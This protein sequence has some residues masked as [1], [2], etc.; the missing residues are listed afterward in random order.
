MPKKHIAEYVV[1]VKDKASGALKDVGKAAEG[2]DKDVKG[3]SE[4]EKKLRIAATATAK[5]LAKHAAATNNAGQAADNAKQKTGALTVAVGNLAAATA[6]AAFQVAKKLP[7]GFIALGKEAIKVSAKLE[8]F[9]TQLGILLKSAEKGKATVRDLFEISKTT[10]FDVESLVEAET[11]LERFGANAPMW[12]QGVMDLAGMMGTDLVYAAKAVG[13]AVAAGAGAADV[14]R[15]RGISATVAIDSG[16]DYAKMSV[17]EFRLALHKTLTTND[18]IVGGTKKLANSYRGIMSQLRDQWIG[19]AREIGKAKLFEGAKLILK[20]VLRLLKASAGASTSWAK[21]IGESLVEGL[22]LA[23]EIFPMI[24]S[25]AARLVIRFHK[26]R[27]VVNLWK[28][29]IEALKLTLIKTLQVA[30]ELAA[31][32]PGASKVGIADAAKRAK[33]MTLDSADRLR[34]HAAENRT[35]QE[36]IK[37]LEGVQEQWSNTSARVTEI[38]EK[39]ANLPKET[40]LKLELEAGLTRRAL[41]Q[42]EEEEKGKKPSAWLDDSFKELAKQQRKAVDLRSDFL[43]K[44]EKDVGKAQGATE[45]LGRGLRDTKKESDKF[46][47]AQQKLMKQMGK[48]AM[49]AKDLGVAVGG[50]EM[51]SYFASLETEI[52]QIEALRLEA[53]EKEL[54]EAKAVDDALK[55]GKAADAAAA[56]SDVLSA[57]TSGP[58]QM[59]AMAGPWGA[60]AAG[61]I[62]IGRGAAQERDA[63][64]EEMAAE[65]AASRQARLEEERAAMMDAGMGTEQLAAMGLSEEDIAKAGEVTAQDIKSA[66]AMAPEDQEFIGKMV[67]DAVKGLIDGAQ[68]IILALPDIIVELIPPLISE[69]IPKLIGAIFKMIPKLLEAIFYE[70]PIAI[71]DGVADWWRKA[72]RDIKYALNPA[73]WVTGKQT[74]GFIPA[75]GNYLLHQ[76]E[77]VVPSSNAATGTARAGLAAFAPPSATVH[78]N[79]AVVDQDTIPALGR[80]INE[81]LGEFGRMSFPVFNNA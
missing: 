64:V 35:I 42:E 76:G 67:S 62:G 44:L 53:L 40:E 3:L 28:G 8:T 69:F 73:N 70:M 7:L 23:L 25:M 39:L 46:D 45:K 71:A 56:A 12:R 20:E 34:A 77:R 47:R 49:I 79:A 66:E 57:A 50:P 58:E 31:K 26:L 29:G 65:K 2:A 78:V 18:K 41:P 63:V 17:D 5:A 14:L 16:M 32:L 1:T 75:T 13:K 21:V 4:E 19:F 81:E 72:W 74:G 27:A 37:V 54:Q 52:K 43:K 36:Q 55:E 30:L 15:E 48:G 38:R 24:M 10:P 61:A 33:W 22:L 59:L 68:A 6:V 80:L 51:T 9:E 11:V 60:A